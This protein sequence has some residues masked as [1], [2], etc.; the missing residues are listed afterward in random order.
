MGKR[1]EVHDM[2][3]TEGADEWISDIVKAIGK[4]SKELGDLADRVM[5]KWNESATAREA[6]RLKM[7]ELQAKNIARF[8]A[9]GGLIVLA[10][11]GISA[12]LVYVGIVSGDALLFFMGSVIGYLFAYFARAAQVSPS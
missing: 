10:F 3:E 11:V 6:H 5:T 1:G 2:E 9:Y 4:H 8:L 12:F 7:A